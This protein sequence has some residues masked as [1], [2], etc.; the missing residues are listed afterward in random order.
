MY[1]NVS[2]S[3]FEGNYARTE[4]GCINNCGVLVVTNS[5]FYKNTAFWWAGAIHTHGG[6]N[7]TIY[8]SD[9]IDNLAGW[10]GGALYTYSYLQIYNTR[11]IGNNCTTNNG[12]GAIGACKYL[13]AAYVHIED[14]IFED[15]ENLCWGLDELSTSGTGRGGAISFMDAGSLEVYNTT[16]VKN[17]ASIGT[18]ICAISGGLSGGSPDV[19]IVGNRFINHT[20]VGDVLDVRVATGSVAEISDNYFE[21]NSIV[22]SKLKL[23]ADDPI[24]GKVMFH[25]DAALKNPASYDEDILDKSKY[26][27]Y[28][29]GVY[30]TTVSSRNFELDLGKGNTANVYVVPCIS[31]SK[32]NE[33]FAGIAKTYIYVS[34][35]RGNDNNDG[36]TRAKP[37]KT[38]NKSIELACSTENIIIMDGTFKETNLVIDYNLTI[39]GENNAAITAT[40][41]IFTITE[42]D[43]KFENLTFKN[44]KYGSSTK[45]RIISQTSTGFLIIDG[46]VFDSNEYKTQVEANVIECENIVASNNKDGS[47]IKAD[48]IVVKSSKFTNNIA[49]YAQGKSII[50][51]KTSKKMTKFEVE[52]LTFIGNT[53]HSGCLIPDITKATITDCTF[54]AN[55]GTNRASVISVEDG[56]SVV[57]Q[58]CK[59][60]N[61][62]D[63]GKYSSVIY[64]TSG[65]VILKDSILINNSYENTNNLII[66][67]NDASLKKLVANN[68]WWGNTP[69]NLTKPALKVFP[70]SF[71]LP[72]GWDPVSYW[73]IINGTALTDE[74]ELNDRVPVQF[75][76]TQIDN[77][78]NITT[79][80][81]GFIPS[82]DL[83]LNA[84]N[85]TCSDKK[86]TMVN[87]MATTY[88]TLTDMAG[89]SLTASFNLKNQYLQ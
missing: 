61:N 3:Y 6:A 65:A 79:F 42:G 68:N 66:N 78:G 11:F 62:T 26:D 17:S 36:S 70:E 52:N 21:N 64:I 28:V 22:F 5:T 47:I 51:Y 38:L 83:T 60:I 67:G 69:D 59:F 8:D 25:L 15:N 73:L 87:G 14:S 39:V 32:S 75:I 82:I 9:F 63:T 88:F 43:V 72:N 20:R 19:R 46:C 48:S 86:I 71:L 23:S 33:V 37:V 55:M 7:T 84:V 10:N 27:V 24:N 56:S 58:S 81:G 57:I 12:G 16:F 45:N 74:I 40:G 35:S 1:W 18:A 85:G 34:Q 89:G 50:M 31:T 2:D 30:K 41:N 80:D 76:F 29:N 13:H 54:I 53:V 77:D 44:C 49:T 4:P